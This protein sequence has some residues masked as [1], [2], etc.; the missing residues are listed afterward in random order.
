MDGVH[1]NRA[2]LNPSQPPVAPASNDGAGHHSNKRNSGGAFTE[3]LKGLSII[4]LFGIGIIILAVVVYVVVGHFDGE[5]SY[6]N[7]SNYQVVSVNVA[8]T[9]AGQAYY[10][11][12]ESITTRY[13]VLDDVFYLQPGQNA[14]QFSLN[15]LSC[16]VYK[17]ADQLIIN[18]TQ[19]AYWTNLNS[20]S[21]LVQ[22]IG[23]WKSNNTQCSSSTPAATSATTP[24][25][26]SS[27]TTQ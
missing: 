24:S 22:D 17:P 15:N 3:W 18:R 14:S 5:S 20:N 2:N 7:K 8:G 25:T 9:S 23:K 21:A 4:L 26:G 13:I 19:V 10:G 6:I 16:L 11:H 1:L 27:S 12:I